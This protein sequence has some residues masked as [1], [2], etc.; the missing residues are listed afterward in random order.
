MRS[1]LLLLL[2][3]LPLLLAAIIVALAFDWRT[4][5][6]RV[7]VLLLHL[8]PCSPVYAS[9][10]LASSPLL[11]SPSLSPILHSRSLHSDPD[12][13]SLQQLDSLDCLA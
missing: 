8:S 1:P 12:P 2:L 7:P 3:L 13:I 6:A 5:C 10:R 9:P 11:P 4:C